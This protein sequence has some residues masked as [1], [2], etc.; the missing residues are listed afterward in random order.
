MRWIRMECR[1]MFMDSAGRRLHGSCFRCCCVL[2]QI[3]ESRHEGGCGAASIRKERPRG[4]R[5]MVAGNV[6]LRNWTA[7]ARRRQGGT[8]GCEGAGR[9]G[10][11]AC[12]GK[13]C[14][15]DLTGSVLL[16]SPLIPA[17]SNSCSPVQNHLHGRRERAGGAGWRA[18]RAE[19]TGEVERAT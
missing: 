8:Q 2:H 11:G 5:Q 14:G 12:H 19:Q 6:Q 1:R 17:H 16:S 18:G 7:T 3:R 10:S 4:G 9:Y 15:T 13:T